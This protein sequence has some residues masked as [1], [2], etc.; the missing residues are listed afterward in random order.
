MNYEEEM[1]ID[2]AKIYMNQSIIQAW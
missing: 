1:K 2:I